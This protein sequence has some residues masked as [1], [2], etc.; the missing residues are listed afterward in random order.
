MKK[1]T[2][3]QIRQEV[4]EMIPLR[5][6][7]RFE[8]L[9]TMII[10]K[11]E[12]LTAD[13]IKQQQ[14]ME[15]ERDMFWSA[16]EDVTCSVLG[17]PSQALYSTTRRREIVTARQI[18]FFIIRPCYLQ[19]YESIGKHYGKDHATVMHGVKQ[20]S[21]QI[22]VD[23]N[24]AAN[25]ERICYLLNDIGYAKPMKFFTKFVEHLEHQKE[26]KLKKLMRKK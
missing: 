19:S 12:R 1:M 6:M 11:Y 5:H 25:V 13:Q 7:E 2:N 9:W 3:E 8:L 15:N 20:A 26:I 22:E 24:Y 23:K 21:W 14:E 16:L 10:P 18:I 17:I 4:A